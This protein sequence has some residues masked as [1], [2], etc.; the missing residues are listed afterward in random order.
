MR[1]EDINSIESEAGIIA[2]LIHNPE[3][4][5]YSE[6]LL[7]NHFVDKGNRCVYTAICDLARQ[8]IMTIDPYNILED[9]NSSEATRKFADELSIDKLQEL[10]DMSDVIARGTVEEYKL[11]VK[12]VM[13]A[14]FRRDTY[15]RLQECQA[16]CCDR[17]AENIEHKIY[18]VIDNVMTEFST[19]NEIP[20][21]KDMVDDCFREIQERQSDG[22]SGIPTKFP[23][24]NEYVTLE[25]G[26][27][28]LFGA[29][30]K[31]GKSM[32]LLNCAV[33]L[34]KKDKAVLYLDSE[35]STR[36]FTARLLAHLSGIKY[37]DLTSGNYSTEEAEKINECIDWI[38]TRKF[39]HIYIPLFDKQ[40]IYTAIKKVYH[41]QGL[42]VLVVDYFKGGD[43]GD[44][45]D[46]YRDLG[47]VVNMIKNQV[48]GDMGIA[49][50]GAIQTTSTGRAAD[51]IRVVRNASTLAILQSKTP[52]EI[53]Q[54][55]I[56]CGN[57]KLRVVYNRN[58]MQMAKGEYIDLFFDGNRVIYE[59][60]K[61]HI[62]QTPY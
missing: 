18:N 7:P 14:A 9:L 16:L 44:A 3:F 49:G 43:E 2:S 50:L 45:F 60:A 25:Q 11:L 23:T 1:P 32:L 4:S 24:L 6:Y 8:G 46:I 59:E 48:C 17:S 12:N 33:D 35:L 27:L 42:D 34:L 21:Y 39:T 31:E 20:P 52:E 29:E 47:G 13:D 5:F 38:K 41:T 54:D 51:S 55:G 56:E 26:E 15:Q 53:E 28:L 57:K 30:P 36:L 62:P 37:R 22:Y 61:Q 10:V 40:S 19:T 58:G